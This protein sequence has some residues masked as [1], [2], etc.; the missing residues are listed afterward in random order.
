MEKM[1]I[2]E[3]MMHNTRPNAGPWRVRVEADPVD[4]DWRYHAEVSFFPGG[5][6]ASSQQMGAQSKAGAV[7]AAVATGFAREAFPWPAALEVSP[8]LSQASREARNELT[9]RRA[10]YQDGDRPRRE[11]D[12]RVG[13]TEGLR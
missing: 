5:V 3:W 8:G 11:V 4:S 2:E 7:L 13:R 9:L 10:L 1:N 12:R 6:F